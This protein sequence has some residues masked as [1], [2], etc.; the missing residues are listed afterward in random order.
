MS[1]EE[2]KGTRFVF[3]FKSP[4]DEV[5]QYN[6]YI[7]PRSL[8]HS[9]AKRHKKRIKFSSKDLKMPVLDKISE[10]PDDDPSDSYEVEEF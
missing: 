2:G 9:K 10:R 1:S 7:N 5:V 4:I 3:A 8:L 6:T